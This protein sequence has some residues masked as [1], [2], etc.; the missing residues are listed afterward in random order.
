MIIK[1]FNR[2]AE[3]HRK[4][5]KELEQKIGDLRKKMADKDRLLKV[6]KQFCITVSKIFNM[7]MTKARQ[8]E[9]NKIQ[10]EMI[11]LKRTRVKLLKQMKEESTEYQ[12]MMQIKDKEIMQYKVGF[13]L[14]FIT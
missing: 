11:S 10:S 3:T 5:C 1:Y 14:F 12:R 4:R 6:T 2:I 13:S 7:Q 8:E 9:I